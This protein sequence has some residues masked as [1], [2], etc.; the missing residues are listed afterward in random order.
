MEREKAHHEGGRRGQDEA[1]ADGQPDYGGP[2][3]R[4]GARE[5]PREQEPD[6]W[7]GRSGYSLGQRVDSNYGEWKSHRVSGGG[8]NGCVLLAYMCSAQ[9]CPSQ[10]RLGSPL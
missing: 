8:S 5:R 2:C 4:L 7:R 3:L 1:M 9:T 10:S 6:S